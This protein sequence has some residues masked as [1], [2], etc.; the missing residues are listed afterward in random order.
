MTPR[1][2]ELTYKGYRKRRLEDWEMVRI[3]SYY[4]MVMHAKEGSLEPIEDKIKLPVDHER[5]KF[6]PKKQL[7][8]DKIMKVR[9]V[10]G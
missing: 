7:S 5:N 9:K 10:N 1:E 3:S 8:K 6:K 2:L 4:Q